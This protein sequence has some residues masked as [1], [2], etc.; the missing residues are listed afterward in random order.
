[1]VDG[2]VA[3]GADHEGLSP[4]SRHQFRP[5]RLWLSRFAK[6]G[7]LADMVNFDV[8]RVL[9]RLASSSPEPFDQLLATD[10]ARGWFTVGQDRFALPSVPRLSE[11][12]LEPEPL[13]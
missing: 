3:G 5:Q 4:L 12:G 10:D 9:A 13:C 11:A 7:E 1:V 8:A 2:V 6:M